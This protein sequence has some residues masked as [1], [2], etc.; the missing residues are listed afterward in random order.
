M[1]HYFQVQR[2]TLDEAIE[3]GICLNCKN[4]TDSL[5]GICKNCQDILDKMGIRECIRK[6][7]KK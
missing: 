1:E 4:R 5:S 6:G 2:L 3:K 7:V